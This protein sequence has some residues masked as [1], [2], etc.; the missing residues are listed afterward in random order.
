MVRRM[1]RRPRLTA[2]AW[3]LAGFRALVTG[4]P[5]AVR[6]EPIARSLGATKGSF[7]WHFPALP[8]LHAAMLVYWEARAFDDVVAL[9]A[10]IPDPADRLRALAEAA[11]LP[12]DADVGGAAAEPALRAWAQVDP[13]VAKAVARVDARRMGYLEDVLSELSLDLPGRARLIY[14]A[15][16]GLT[17]LEAR[18]G[19][20]G[21]TAM[22]DLVSLILESDPAPRG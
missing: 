20:G 13:A 2:E 9:L 10:A 11:V 22:A 12:P 4:G 18:D 16:L 8:D 19:L 17:E 14:G 1:A 6:V 21:L 15:Y 7:Y 5:G 3:V